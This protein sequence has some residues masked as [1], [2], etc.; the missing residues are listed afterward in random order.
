[1]RRSRETARPAP[2]DGHHPRASR[3]PLEGLRVVAFE[4]AVAMPYCTFLLAE[5]GADVVKVERPRAVT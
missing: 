1:M 2:T 3:K 5:L 4:Q